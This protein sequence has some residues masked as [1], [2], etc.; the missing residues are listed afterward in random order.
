MFAVARAIQGHQLQAMS[1]RR[2]TDEEVQQILAL[3]AEADTG[4]GSALRENTGMTL[5][6]VQRI[7]SE[8]GISAGAVAISAAVIDQP[9]TKTNVSGLAMQAAVANTVPLAR[10]LTDA[11]WTRLVAQL[12]DTFQAEG[13]VTEA[14]GRREWRNGNL[15]VAVQTIGDGAVLELRTRKQS[16]RSLV[17][18]GLA[19]LAGS[20]ITSI[21][22]TVAGTSAES[23]SGILTLAITGVAM[24]AAG[25][26]P[27]P[28]WLSERRRQF[29]SVAD[30]VRRLAG[31]EAKLLP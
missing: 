20:G 24:T 8:A 29:A 31:G 22:T 25:I 30:F 6:E 3:A 14:P 10:P 2:Y 27:V 26:L 11:E 13:R 1:E 23:L 21:A 17:R 9:G 15:R 7:A 28:L 12:R 4:T 19:L 16:A 18:V 5:A